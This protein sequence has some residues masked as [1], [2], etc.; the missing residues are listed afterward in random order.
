LCINNRKNGAAGGQVGKVIFDAVS[1]EKIHRG[2]A[3]TRRMGIGFCVSP[4][5][6]LEAKEASI[7]GLLLSGF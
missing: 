3:E 2:G 4:L 1:G 5:F 7:S 6:E